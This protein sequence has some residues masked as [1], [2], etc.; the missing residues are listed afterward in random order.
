MKKIFL[1][2]FFGFLLRL[3]LSVQFYSGD[4]NNHIAWAK[5]ILLNGTFSIYEREFY[6]RYGTLT[7]NYPPLALFL[8][9]VSYSLYEQI[10][11]LSI[12]FNTQFSLFPSQVIWSLQHPNIIPAFLK[13]PGILADIG[14]SYVVYLFAKKFKQSEKWTLIS[15]SF[16]LFNPAFFYNSALWGQI[17][18][19]P[20][21]FS[22]LAL[23]LLLYSKNILLAFLIF[24]L[25]ILSKQN[26]V[27]LVPVYFLIALQSNTLNKL[28]RPLMASFIL[29]WGLFVPFSGLN[30]V[31]AITTYWNKI[32]TNSVSDYVSYHAFNFWTLFIGL[33]K[34]HDN[35]IFLFGISYQIFGYL[36]FG[37][38]TLFLLYLLWKNKNEHIAIY[39]ATIISF[40]SFL[41]LTR[42][43][44]RHL[45][46][47]LPLLLLLG[48]K[49]KRFL[50]IFI[51]AS[52][53]Y[54]LNLYHDWWAPRI[55]L[56]VNFI[57]NIL[58]IKLM[59][60]TLLILFGLL[61]VRFNKL[62][63]YLSS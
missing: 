24:T 8:F 11:N 43:H 34:V 49:N 46:P 16:V 44:E 33:D 6:F 3:Y 63:K 50:P 7:P 54:V 12:W 22:I 58:V 28:I 2:L 55:P 32:L 59:V 31:T 9:T 61:L 56:L 35:S 39:S 21:L 38:I 40:S 48:I 17:D 36:M 23:Y 25:G 13:I 4:V 27:I 37:L 26:I 57:S 14:I 29:F 51:F 60:F 10:Y 30:A 41:F 5:D 1:L 53:F 45:E 42:L 18:A 47:T 20:I 52:L 19:L 15:A 62:R